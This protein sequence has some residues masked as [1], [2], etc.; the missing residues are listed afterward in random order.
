MIILIYTSKLYLLKNLD[1][2]IIK[3]E[4]ITIFTIILLFVLNINEFFI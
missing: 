2:F 1:R 3:Y 4:K